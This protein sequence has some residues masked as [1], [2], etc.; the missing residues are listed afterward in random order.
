LN[1][2]AGQRLRRLSLIANNSRFWILKDAHVPNLATRALR[3]CL[4]RLS[5][6]WQAQY[7]HPILVV[8]SFVDPSLQGTCY[9]AGNWQVLGQ[10][11]GY[12]RAARDYYTRHDT[13]KQLWVK[14]LRPGGRELLKARRLP[15]WLGAQLAEQGAACA[16]SEEELRGMVKHFKGLRDWRERLGDYPLSGLVALVACATLCGVQ[17]GQRDLAAFAATLTPRQ[18]KAL[19]FRKRGWPRRYQAPKE[20]TFFRFLSKVDHGELQQALLAWQE[21]VLGAREADDRL[22]AFDGKKLRSSQGVEIT[23]LYAVKSG[24]WLGSELTENKSNEIPAARA[25]LRRSDLQGCLVVPDALHCN[26]ETAQVIV[27]EGGADYL[28]PVKGNQPG[29]E[30]NLAA[31]ERNLQRA[32]SPSTADGRRAARGTQ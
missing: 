29:V 14:E 21:Q 16:A 28:L 1:W 19:G 11:Q 24:R 18:M 8:E 22:L 30:E 3:L 2:T 32:F 4:D 17:R 9:R 13:P 31:I 7:G 15:E 20:T 6:D 5:A 10:T 25:L 26:A 27:Q 12:G 23:S